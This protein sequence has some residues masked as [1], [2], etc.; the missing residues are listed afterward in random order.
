MARKTTIENYNRALRIYKVIEDLWEDVELSRGDNPKETENKLLDALNTL[1]KYYRGVE[2]ADLHGY[3]DNEKISQVKHNLDIFKETKNFIE[4]KIVGG[5][6]AE[7]LEDTVKDYI[8]RMDLSKEEYHPWA[9]NIPELVNKFLGTI[10]NPR[11]YDLYKNHIKRI[12][13]ATMT[14]KEFERLFD[15]VKQRMVR[16][17]RGF[18]SQNDYYRSK[19][20]EEKPKFG[21]RVK[22]KE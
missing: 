8:N 19:N 18:Q 17:N 2:T 16:K 10:V 13:L 20:A 6:D 11:Y 21:W 4:K 3:V 7:I 5:Q 15:G 12:Q 9:D 22:N 1:E 14:Q